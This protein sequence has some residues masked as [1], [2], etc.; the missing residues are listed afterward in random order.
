[1]KTKNLLI[2]ILIVESALV[3]VTLLLGKNAWV[4]IVC[5]WAVLL[6]KNIFDYIDEKGKKP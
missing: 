4:G 3:L 2:L 1:M 5:Y 6:M